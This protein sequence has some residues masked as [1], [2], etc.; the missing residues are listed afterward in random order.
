MAEQSQFASEV[1]QPT[2]TESDMLQRRIADFKINLAPKTA[3]AVS[4]ILEVGLQKGLYKLADLD[5][6]ITIREEIQK[7]IIEYN[8]QFKMAQ[9]RLNAIAEEEQANVGALR[10]VELDKQSEELRVQRLLARDERVKSQSLAEELQVLK[11]IIA[12]RDNS[13]LDIAPVQQVT[14]PITKPLSPAFAAARA[15]NPIPVSTEVTP[16]V[17][18]EEVREDIPFNESD[19]DIKF[20]GDL[21]EKVESAKQAFADYESENDKVTFDSVPQETAPVDTS[22]YVHRMPVPES[23]R[24]LETPQVKGNA[25]SLKAQIPPV[26]EVTAPIEPVKPTPSFE[27]EE[28]LLAHA[29]AKLDAKKAEAEDE[30]DEITIPSSDELQRMTKT[31]IAEV[32][33]DLGI[34]L[35]RAEF[36]V[37]TNDTK[38]VM[39]SSFQ[40]Q[41]E[42]LISD[43]KESDEFVSATDDSGDQ[44]ADTDVRDGG[45]F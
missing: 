40:D 30:F 24:I 27:T 37:D 31:K 18:Q 17:V 28:E 41:V 7:G 23:G 26:Q 38:A 39:I 11:D 44:D 16:D 25:P 1:V 20:T 4:N 2:I 9:T 22:E 32:V 34:K 29:Q 6:L 13:T 42:T 21:G 14:P 3:D 36:K 19:E 15:L 8:T 10:Q 45:Y 5:M 33:S 43:L 35:G 12:K